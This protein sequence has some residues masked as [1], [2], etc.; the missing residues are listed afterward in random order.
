MMLAALFEAENG[1][2]FVGTAMR[3][4]GPG[5]CPSANGTRNERE[6]A[7]DLELETRD[8]AI[9]YPLRYKTQKC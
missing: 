6:I 4:I 2:R 7:T 1:K 9:H 3:T 8:T 5:N